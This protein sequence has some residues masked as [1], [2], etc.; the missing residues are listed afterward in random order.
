MTEQTPNLEKCTLFHSG[1]YEAIKSKI[2][3]FLET[4]KPF[5]DVPLILTVDGGSCRRNYRG[6]TIR[7]WHR[8]GSVR[9]DAAVELL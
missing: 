5:K 4:K 9:Y 8:D 1:S 6:I 7:E 3:V 2:D